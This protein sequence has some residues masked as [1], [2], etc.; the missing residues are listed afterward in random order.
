VVEVHNPG[1]SIRV[2]VAPRLAFQIAVLVLF[3]VFV[4]VVVR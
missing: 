2:A 1:L 4:V 3:A